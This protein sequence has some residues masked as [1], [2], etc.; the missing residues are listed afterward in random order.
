MPLRARRGTPKGRIVGSEPVLCQ[1]DS[2][3]HPPA[4]PAASRAPNVICQ[5][6]LSAWQTSRS[7]AFGSFRTPPGRPLR[8][9]PSSFPFP[10]QS[11]P[12]RRA[13]GAAALE[14]RPFPCRPE[15]PP[16]RPIQP[17]LAT[18]L[19]HAVVMPYDALGSFRTRPG[20]TGLLS[21]PAPGAYPLA[22]V[23]RFVSHA[24]RPRIPAPRT[25]LPQRP[26]PP[27]AGRR[28]RRAAAT[29]VQCTRPNRQRRPRSLSLRTQPL[30][31]RFVWSYTPCAPDTADSNV[32]SGQ[33]T[34][35]AT[36][37]HWCTLIRHERSVLQTRQRGE[38]ADGRRCTQ[39]RTAQPT[40]PCRCRLAVICVHQCPPVADVRCPSPSPRSV[41]P[42]PRRGG[43]L[44]CPP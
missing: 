15:D 32:L 13:S 3:Q 18:R 22:P 39:M 33:R 43:S 9:P 26:A 20:P 38:T 36:D 17:V 30:S 6:R 2:P 34:T 37:P 40:E 23:C 24:A 14:E 4:P 16:C 10:P 29:A 1:P 35:G 42:R 25:D 41:A 5:V 11:A 27:K 8:V 19:S 28:G 21:S 44:P 7:D 31:V 12:P